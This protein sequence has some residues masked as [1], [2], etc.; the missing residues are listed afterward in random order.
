MAN[1]YWVGGTDTWDNTAGSKWSLTSGGAGGETVPTTADDVFFDANSGANTVTI[2]ITA[3]TRTLTM[4]GF[5]G[6]LA[7]GTNKIQIALSGT[8]TVFTGAT[9]YSVTGTPL[10]ELTGT[11]GNRTITTGAVTEA[12]SISFSITAGTTGTIALSNGSRVRD[13]DFTGF[14]GVFGNNT[15]TIYG[16]AVF[17]TGMTFTTGNLETQWAGTGTQTITSNGRT[18]NGTQNFAGVGGTRILADNFSTPNPINLTN[19]TFD[20]SASNYS[21]TASA[22]NLGA[23]TKTLNLNASAVTLSGDGGFDFSTN[24]TNFTFN[25]GTST[26]TVTGSGNNVQPHPGGFTFYN[27]VFTGVP[28][29]S[30]NVLSA[31]TYNNLTFPTSTGF[32]AIALSGNQ[33]INGTLT[34]GTANTAAT[35]IFVRS[36]TIGTARTIT[37]AAIATLSDVDFRDITAA[38][39]SV[40]WSGTRLGN[41]LGNTNITFDAP[42]T[43]YWNLSGT[44]NWDATAWAAS[45]GGVPAV[46]NFPLAQDTAVFDEAGAAGTIGLGSWNIGTIDMSTRTTAFTLNIFAISAPAIYGSLTFFS[47]LTL[48]GGLSGLVFAGRGVTQ[49]ITSAGKTFPS[50]NTITIENLT[51]TVQLADAFNSLASLTLTSGTFNASNQNVTCTTFASSNSNTRTL[52]MGSGTWTLSSTGTVWNTGT[53]T[54]L[55]L[56]ANTSTIAF[57]NTSTTAK[58]FAGGGRTYYNLSISP[59]TGI[60]DYIITGANTFNQISSAKTVAYSITLPAA[61]T[62]TV[63]TW[64]AG[65]SSGNLL[66]LRS[67]TY[68][69][70]NTSATL[71]VTNT[72]TTD[73][74]NVALVNLSASGIGTV[75][76][77]LVLTTSGTGN[78]TTPTAGNLLTSGTSWTVPSNWNNSANNIYIFGAGGGGSGTIWVATTSFSG[79]AGGG[80]GGYR[81][82]TNQTYS[83]SVTYAIGAAGASG[84]SGGTSGTSTGG[85]GGTTTWDTTNIATGG[86]G[87][88][89]TATTSTGGT[90]GTGASTGGTGGAGGVTISGTNTGTGGGGGGGAAGV[91]GNGGNGGTG[92]NSTGNTSIAGGGGG[93]NGGGTAGGNAASGVGGNGGNNSLG[94]GGATGAT[95]SGPVPATTATNG[96][97]GGGSTGA[98]GASASVGS[99]GIDIQ[100]F[101]GGG[102]GGPG[103]SR[104]TSGGSLGGLYG[105][106]GGGGSSNITG[107]RTSAAAGRQ[108]AIIIFWTPT[109]GGTLFGSAS[110]N[111]T[112]TVT[113]L[114]DYTASGLGSISASA[115]VSSS[116]S[117]T[118]SVS[119]AINGTA[120]VSALGGLAQFGIA[121]IN[122]TASVSALGG[123]LNSGQASI[124]ANGTVTANGGLLY[125]GQASVN[126]TAT[127]TA[128]GYYIADGVAAISAF[129][130]VTA[131]A[132]GVVTGTAFITANGTVIANGV[133]QGEGW[134]P[135]TPG[136]ETWTTITAGTET[137]TDISPS[138]D[139]W[140]RQG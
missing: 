64:S 114:G 74:A 115:T 134:T 92:F 137:W 84:G 51:G 7:F 75:T 91:N 132:G 52:T 26:I 12:Q 90:G 131:I 34:L 77:G 29:F 58:T 69:S 79:G 105:A 138:T 96:G 48:G 56:N 19:G 97:G 140:L 127:V 133:I 119:G 43:V 16:N 5:T 57:S 125:S 104:D 107:S 109:G 42:K 60:A 37:A 71:A 1:R 63:T 32:Y 124:T 83:G 30:F 130:E 4:T 3:P 31:G 9:T 49:T 65:G 46:N 15:R 93:G 111:G 118:F 72:F 89:T 23:G 94:S 129:A 110:I 40:T 62:T 22:I 61:T 2:G 128:D 33:T 66:T 139:I 95:T 45:S 11:S 136:T 54:N 98:V 28:I 67:S 59:A 35:R 20:T 99:A 86:T 17:S 120:T 76:N 112:A 8:A 21:I 73:Y 68:G 53:T 100:S 13:L 27:V 123:L 78:W 103:G 14:S 88:V 39:A 47:N 10:I 70:T 116:S 113:G 41:C 44:R 38:G 87:G 135:I 101:I 108:G 85:T 80:G 81:S 122:G 82:L 55:T 24:S 25:A 106:G 117:L 50:P 102:G 6:T 18:I 36:N 126:G 121:S